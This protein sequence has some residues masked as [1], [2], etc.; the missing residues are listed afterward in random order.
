MRVFLEFSNESRYSVVSKILIHIVV[1][2]NL[3]FNYADLLVYASLNH[4]CREVI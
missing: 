1:T 4:C 3:V 2:N